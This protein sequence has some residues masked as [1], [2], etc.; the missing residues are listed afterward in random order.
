MTRSGVFKP[1]DSDGNSVEVSAELS[2]S[3]ARS[4]GTSADEGG[5]SEEELDAKAVAPRSKLRR[6]S[7]S[8][9]TPCG[10]IDGAGEGGDVSGGSVGSGA[11][12]EDSCD[13]GEFG[14][15]LDPVATSTSHGRKH[16]MKI[17]K[18][19]GNAGIDKLRPQ[20]ETE[21][22]MRR[23]PGQLFDHAAPSQRPRAVP[24][25]G[26][27]RPASCDEDDGEDCGQ[28]SDPETSDAPE[29]HMHEGAAAAA[30][31]PRVKVEPGASDGAIPLAL[32]RNALLQP[33]AAVAA[34]GGGPGDGRE[35]G[36]R[37]GGGSAGAA[38]GG[39]S[40]E[41]GGGASAGTGAAAD[42]AAVPA[43]AASGA[44]PAQWR[45]GGRESVRMSGAVR[46]VLG[47]RRWRARAIATVPEATVLQG[48]GQAATL[49][50][51]ESDTD[52]S[53]ASG[54]TCK[55]APMPH[56]SCHL[57]ISVPTGERAYVRNAWVHPVMHVDL[58]CAAG[59][60]S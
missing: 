35:G 55:C 48:E 28:T 43:A 17:E 5:A 4:S 22:L 36:G 24:G 60:A 23:G 34:A 9:R 33:V 21:A 25:V 7:I 50:T 38:A 26:V 2:G 51:G 37:S 39:E 59:H 12:G 31:V 54:S 56:A 13:S 30:P 20:P 6:A 1:V 41:V 32:R 11:V 42:G 47:A 19:E 58:L 14:P 40:A 10:G 18:A 27:T 15:E 53:T 52:A 46:A 45:E 8:L 49:L 3:G 44:L 57:C 16:S 29:L